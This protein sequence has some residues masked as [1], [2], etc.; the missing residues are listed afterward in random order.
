MNT[1]S[2]GQQ[3]LE[4]QILHPENWKRTQK[5]KYSI[6][7]K[8]APIGTEIY[9]HLEK[10]HYTT[11]QERN[12]VLSGTVG[13]QWIIDRKR[14]DRTYS[15]REGKPVAFIQDLSLNNGWTKVFSIAQ[16][17]PTAAVIQ[18]PREYK[19]IKVKTSW[20]DILTANSSEKVVKGDFILADLDQNGQP[21]MD[22]LRMVDHDIFLNTY[23][24]KAFLKEEKTQLSSISLVAPS[25]FIS[26]PH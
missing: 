19:D 23:D 6:W 7:A 15:D 2:M 24:S 22:K 16:S 3:W 1:I 4:E 11:T 20:G 12:I 8:E 21:K 14:L 25:E 26:M 5:L 9:N 10:T 13:E 18:I 17:H